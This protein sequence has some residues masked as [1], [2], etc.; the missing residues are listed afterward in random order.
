MSR[1]APSNGREIAERISASNSSYITESNENTFKPDTTFESFHHQAKIPISDQAL[2]VGFLTL[3]LKRRV[4]PT[5]PY[6]VVT[7]V[8]YPAILLA[9]GKSISFLPAIVAGIQ[10]SLRAL[11]K[12]MCQVK[13]VLDPQ[14]KPVM[15]SEGMPEVKTPNPRVKL[16]YT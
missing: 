1:L 13:A 12:S 2:L 3:W 9:H 4:V 7:D 10:S 16:P 11:T 15:D 14:G 8:V 6:E 5:L